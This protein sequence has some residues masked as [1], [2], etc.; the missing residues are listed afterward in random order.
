MLKCVN[1]SLYKSQ[2]CSNYHSST[3]L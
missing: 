2:L 3:L 1:S